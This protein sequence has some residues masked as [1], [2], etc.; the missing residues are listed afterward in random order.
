MRKTTEPFKA[1]CESR[2]SEWQGQAVY[3]HSIQQC[4]DTEGEGNPV[5]KKS[6]FGGGSG[7]SK[8]AATE[9]GTHIVKAAEILAEAI[10]ACKS[11]PN[12]EWDELG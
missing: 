10:R 12:T 2:E 9:L 11:D 1:D 7:M 3:N 4:Y 8:E 6:S 5:L